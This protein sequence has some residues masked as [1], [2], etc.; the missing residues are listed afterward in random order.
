[1]SQDPLQDGRL[2]LKSES[3]VLIAG[4]QEGQEW[5]LKATG[6]DHGYHIFTLPAMAPWTAL[7]GESQV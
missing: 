7:Y 4:N 1:M 6:T 5:T 3:S 2:M